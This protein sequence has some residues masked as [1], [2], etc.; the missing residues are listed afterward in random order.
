MLVGL[1]ASG[2]TTFAQTIKEKMFKNKNTVILSSDDVREELF[3]DVVNN[4]EKHHHEKVFFT[5]QSR[6]LKFLNNGTN[7]IYDATN[8]RRKNRVKII[9]RLPKNC[10]K[11]VFYINKNIDNILKDNKKR[12]RVV[13]ED[14]IKRMYKQLQ[15]PIYSEG[16]DSIGFVSSDKP[17][18]EDV[19]NIINDTLKINEP[20]YNEV[21][22]TLSIIREFM[23][24]CELPHDSTYHSYSV[25]R[26]TYYA[27][28]FIQDYIQEN[29]VSEYNAEVLKWAILLHDVGKSFCKSFKNWRGEETKYANF[30]GHEFVGSQIAI[31][32]LHKLNKPHKLMYDVATLVQFHMYLLNENVNLAKLMHRVGGDLYDLLQVIR[33]ADTQAH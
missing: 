9:N 33:K 6:T 16:W 1:P 11:E 4:Q 2:K 22:S 19:V 31:S 7:V 29:D 14:V 30:I 10:I 8:I 3:G 17:Y 27:Y 23:Q 12:D 15:I 5:M 26:H 21:F 24:I 13:P 28:R 20:T 25:S 32:V 18:T